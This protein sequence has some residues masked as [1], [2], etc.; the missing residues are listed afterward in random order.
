MVNS[1]GKFLSVKC[2]EVNKLSQSTLE[3]F[4]KF[5]QS[6]KNIENIVNSLPE[7][8][9]GVDANA[10]ESNIGNY[11]SLLKQDTDY[12]E[13]LGN[14]FKSASSTY[15]TTISSYDSRFSV[16]ET[17]ADNVNIKALR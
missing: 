17:D 12:F 1:M 7:C 2:D 8:W 10:F 4:K 9:E 16:M 13:Y 15:D 6:R 3:N 11:L 14:Y 5:E